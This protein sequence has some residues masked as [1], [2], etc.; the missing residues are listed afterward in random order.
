VSNNI[1]LAELP[2]EPEK[3]T[4]KKNEETP[5]PTPAPTVARK[6]NNKNN[7]NTD[8]PT[9]APTT[10]KNIDKNNVKETPSPTPGPTS[11]PT[12]EPTEKPVTREPSERPTPEPTATLTEAPTVL[13]TEEPTTIESE[14]PTELVT[15]EPSPS[16]TESPST[17]PS[18]APSI[19]A[20]MSPSGQP[21]A[22]P[23]SAPSLTP[24]GV[25]TASFTRGE[26]T[27]ALVDFDVLLSS[28]SMVKYEVFRYTLEGYLLRDMLHDNRVGVSLKILENYVRTNNQGK[29]ITLLRFSGLASFEDGVP[30]LSEVR[31]DQGYLLKDYPKVQKAIDDNSGLESVELLEISFDRLDTS[32]FRVGASTEDEEPEDGPRYGTWSLVAIIAGI[33]AIFVIG[34][35]CIFRQGASRNRQVPPAA[36]PVRDETSEN[37]K[38]SEMS[39]SL[40]KEGQRQSPEQR[41][42]FWGLGGGT[43]RN[44]PGQ[45]GT[46]QDDA[47]ESPSVRSASVYTK[48]EQAPPPQ[49][50]QARPQ[51]QQNPQWFLGFLRS[52]R[53]DR[54]QN[55]QEQPTTS[56][57][58]TACKDDPS[59]KESTSSDEQSMG[60]LSWFSWRKRRPTNEIEVKLERSMI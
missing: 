10:N 30:P 32:G 21:S 36:G 2:D 7:K 38:I 49:E 44:G 16:P 15:E 59:A 48:Q 51:Q 17:A 31:A 56:L 50:E 29:T 45:Q 57:S 47:P 54:Q 1:F 19:T 55:G 53:Q 13:K 26:E 28:D 39:A 35:C 41:H 20:S 25:P 42:W 40:C 60:G 9:M 18:I 8:A 37:G 4:R 11:A 58:N 3:E 6:R 33:A 46:Q 34:A 52:N 43:L 24:T 23:S 27:A 22:K 14:E 5:A 12:E